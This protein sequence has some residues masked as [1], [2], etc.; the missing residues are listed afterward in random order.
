MTQLNSVQNPDFHILFEKCPG[1]YL[2]LL[3]D[4]QFTIVAVTDAYTRV[5][6]TQ[7]LDILHRGIFEIFPDNPD[8]PHATGVTNLTASL[9]RVILHKTH[10]VMAVQKYD[11]RRPYSEGGN[12]EERYWCLVNSPVFGSDRQLLYIIHSVEDV[13]EFIKLKQKGKE[14]SQI[15]K[16]LQLQSDKMQTE[17][18]LHEQALQR[19]H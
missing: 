15:A 8:D 3:P 2:V 18:I 7:P 17:I 11:I 19:A 9:N 16:Q 13:T 5:T 14:Q 1:Q 12:F 6:M 4:S 10:D